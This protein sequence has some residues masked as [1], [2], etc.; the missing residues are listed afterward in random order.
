[1][2]ELGH[3]LF[4]HCEGYEMPDYAAALVCAIV[5]KIETVFWNRNQYEWDR[6]EDPRVPGL[7]FRPYYWGDDDSEAALPNLVLE[8]W[9]DQEIRWYKHVGRDMMCTHNYTPDMWVKWFDAALATVRA[10]DREDL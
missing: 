9:Q 6:R 4:G 8:G 7:T 1:M 10:A 5:D 2:I 3:L